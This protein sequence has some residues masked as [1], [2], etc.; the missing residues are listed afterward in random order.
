[1]QYFSN[2]SFYDTILEE[3]TIAP[4][5]LASTIE[6]A[7]GVYTLFLTII[8]VELVPKNLERKHMKFSLIASINLVKKKKKKFDC[9]LC[10][11][12]KI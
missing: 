2:N 10:F 6:Q 8:K 11:P 1:M 12:F 3:I 5:M 4:S 9:S 7:Q